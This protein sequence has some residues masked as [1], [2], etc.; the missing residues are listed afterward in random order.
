MKASVIICTYNRADLLKESILSVQNQDF[1]SDQYEIIVVDNNSADDT[2]DVVTET[3]KDSPVRIIYVF[4]GKQGLS[5]ARNTGINNSD[6]E[7]IVFT[8]DDV[9]AEK[10]WLRELVAA[11]I[12]HLLRRR[13]G[14]TRARRGD[15]DRK[16]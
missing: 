10:S 12:R 15:R 8:D 2:K 14:H 4:E 6:G 7:I 13:V 11:K 9:E 5:H 1:P 16:S 3:A